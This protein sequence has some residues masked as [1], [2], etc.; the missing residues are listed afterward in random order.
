MGVPKP[1]PES[2]ISVL[3]GGRFSNLNRQVEKDPHPSPEM[4]PE[5]LARQKKIYP[6]KIFAVVLLIKQNAEIAKSSNRG[7]SDT[8]NRGHVFTKG[9][10]EK[11]VEDSG[12]GNVFMTSSS[13]GRGR[14][15]DKPLLR[16]ILKSKKQ[17]DATWVASLLGGRVR[18]CSFIIHFS[19]LSSVEE[20]S[21]HKSRLKSDVLPDPPASPAPGILTKCSFLRHRNPTP[22]P[23]RPT[24]H[25]VSP[26]P[27]PAPHHVHPACH[28]A[29]TLLAPH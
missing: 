24:P 10:F 19:S 26:A 28:G 6:L 2:P 11:D 3:S 13:R 9:H 29:W 1:V 15:I 16:L 12:F 8:N 17:N 25:L 4:H 5:E 14:G 7:K 18:K 20:G 23:P 21:I 27:C 22:T